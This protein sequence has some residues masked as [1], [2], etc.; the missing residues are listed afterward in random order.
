MRKMIQWI[1]ILFLILVVQYLMCQYVAI[2]SAVYRHM[3]IPEERSVLA[4]GL[5]NIFQQEL[6]AD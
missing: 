3:T 2:H 5:Y 1:D 6:Q 4:F